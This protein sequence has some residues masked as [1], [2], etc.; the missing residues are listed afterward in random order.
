MRLPRIALLAVTLLALSAV[1]CSASPVS[2]GIGTGWQRFSWVENLVTPADGFSFSNV[3][4]VTVR[5]TDAFNVGDAFNIFDNGNP[6]FAT[7]S[8]TNT[9]LDLTSDPDV[10][11]AGTD[12]SH[13]AFT[14][15]GGS[16]VLTIGIRDHALGF[17]NGGAFLRA[18][19]ATPEPGSLLLLGMGLAA[20]ALALKRRS[21]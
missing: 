9:G 15:G 17:S 1:A 3:N 18:D 21:A 7:P 12:Y 19:A 13:A 4:P 6:A 10:A 20:G 16:H 2:L 8:V 11:F 5:V 14:F